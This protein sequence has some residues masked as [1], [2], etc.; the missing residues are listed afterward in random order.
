MGTNQTKQEKS[1]PENGYRVNNIL[2]KILHEKLGF[3]FLMK[4][5]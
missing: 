2:K 3:Y 1:I 4:I 5:Y